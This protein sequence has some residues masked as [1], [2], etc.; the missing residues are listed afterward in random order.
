MAGNFPNVSRRHKPTDSR[1]RVNSK[2]NKLKETRQQ[3]SQ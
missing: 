3:K 2:Q 1:N